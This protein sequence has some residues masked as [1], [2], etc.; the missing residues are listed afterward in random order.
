MSHTN[1]PLAGVIGCP[2]GH[3]LSP[4]LHGHWLKRY[5]IAGHYVP[6]EVQPDDLVEVLGAMSR[7]GFVGANVTIPHKEAALRLADQVS[8]RATLIGAANTLIFR[9]DHTIY[10]DNTDGYGFMQNLRQNCPDWNPK[11]GPA[12]VIGAGGASRAIIVALL[13]AGVPEIRLTNRTRLR[14]DQLKS[15]FGGKISVYDWVHLDRM[16][17]GAATLVNTTSQGMVGNPPLKINLSDLPTSALVT[18]IVYTP[19]ETPLLAQA[20][21]HGCR[22]VDGLGMLLHQAVPGFYRWFGT[23]PTV[24]EELRQVVLG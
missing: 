2:V 23:Q 9:P 1:I 7:M 24:D 22:T 10:A 17:E 4:R 6:L 14:A 19:L 13:D 5:G 11:A 18:D 20:R 21:E 15:E 8:D 12:V 16:L 3:S